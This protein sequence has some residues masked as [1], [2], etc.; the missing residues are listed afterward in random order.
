MWLPLGQRVFWGVFVTAFYTLCAPQQYSVR[1][2][3]YP[4]ASALRAK[5]LEQA[6]ATAFL[7]SQVHHAAIATFSIPETCADTS[8]YST[9]CSVSKL[10]YTAPEDA[11]HSWPEPD[12]CIGLLP[13]DEFVV[14]QTQDSGSLLTP[15]VSSDEAPTADISLGKLV[16]DGS[17]AFAIA[18]ILTLLCL[19]YWRPRSLHLG[20]K[21]LSSAHGAAITTETTFSLVSCISRRLESSEMSVPIFEDLSPRDIRKAIRQTG[22]EP[23][24]MPIKL[25]LQFLG[26]CL[27]TFNDGFWDAFGKRSSRVWTGRV[28][29]LTAKASDLTNQV[30]VLK[31]NLNIKEKELASNKDEFER[32]EEELATKKDEL[33]TKE[34]ELATNNHHCATKE[35][36]LTKVQSLLNSANIRVELMTTDLDSV[37]ERS[38]STSSE[39][40]MATKTADF[41]QLEAGLAVDNLNKSQ[42]EV[43]RIKHLLSEE[44]LA[45]GKAD[46]NV[47]M[48]MGEKKSLEKSNKK[49]SGKF[50]SLEQENNGFRDSLTQEERKLQ[51]LETEK[52]DQK[53]E[54]ENFEKLNTAHTIAATQLAEEKDRLLTQNNE[55]SEVITAQSAEIVVMGQTIDDLT[56]S[57]ECANESSFKFQ[58]KCEVAE[59]ERE[60]A[61]KKAV[62]ACE[63][64][65]EA[66]FEAL[67]ART[68]A[69][70]CEELLYNC[71]EKNDDLI[72]ENERL[73]SEQDEVFSAV[74]ERI[75][76][77]TGTLKDL[78]HKVSSLQKENLNFQASITQKEE[79]LRT[80]D[81]KVVAL[82][83]QVGNQSDLLLEKSEHVLELERDLADL[84]GKYKLMNTNGEKLFGEFIEQRELILGLQIKKE[85]LR[86]YLE[87]T[88][89]EFNTLNACLAAQLT[90]NEDLL[91]EQRCEIQQ[92]RTATKDSESSNIRLEA[93]LRMSHQTTQCTPVQIVT[94]P[95]RKHRAGKQHAKRASRDTQSNLFAC[96]EVVPFGGATYSA[97]YRFNENAFMVVQDS[98]GSITRRPTLT[99][100]C[101]LLLGVKTQ[102]SEKDQLRA[103]QLLIKVDFTPAHEALL[104]RRPYQSKDTLKSNVA[105]RSHEIGRRRSAIMDSHDELLKK[106]PVDYPP[107]GYR[108]GHPRSATTASLQDSLAGLEI[109]APEKFSTV[110]EI[111]APETENLL[112]QSPSQS[113]SG[114]M[115]NGKRN[116]DSA[117]SCGGDA[118]SNTSQDDREVKED[119]QFE[120][121]SEVKDEHRGK[122]APHET[123]THNSNDGSNA[124]ES[125]TP[126]EPQPNA[127][128]IC[129]RTNHTIC[130]KCDRCEQRGEPF[131]KVWG[132]HTTEACSHNA[133]ARKAMKGKA[134]HDSR[135][136]RWREQEVQKKAIDAAYAA[137]FLRHRK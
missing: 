114:A 107:P 35:A 59:S 3:F 102:P 122:D 20:W 33:K 113:T 93:M 94:K 91:Q 25:L 58:R 52:A 112:A 76:K 14:P 101:L 85:E 115:C 104:R 1:Q 31:E 133:Q 132:S 12:Q 71:G 46:K 75:W 66:K 72:K 126:P 41:W 88:K 38:T 100:Y 136:A 95:R 21:V 42:D 24:H 73:R 50:E 108:P 45:R 55:L 27:L 118:A 109:G 87:S 2:F 67:K 111:S 119:R 80:A 10:A 34:E 68:T 124:K 57:T 123:P 83:A 110:T 99:F 30:V 9:N 137:R 43:K 60:Q 48:V 78:E 65:V 74:S 84:M 77:L 70:A 56:V 15:K 120:K 128:N 47:S 89:I 97:L 49:L 13:C 125:T 69:F 79:Q 36:E 106:L 92:L 28:Q 129:K 90:C 130:W 8:T 54:I 134:L 51:M 11:N 103:L 135:V 116:S 4:E 127:C 64:T 121:N 44:Q 5:H 18:T 86:S 17:T 131:V 22:P 19:A 62:E 39:L 61:V 7:S 96:P 6:V 117:G 26:Y 105:S 82:T 32:R 53:R 37:V 63:Q 98:A 40:K 23:G 81:A 16:V 29:L